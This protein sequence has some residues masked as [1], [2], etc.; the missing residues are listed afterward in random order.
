[1]PPTTPAGN[2]PPHGVPP[3]RLPVSTYR[4]QF[5]RGFT[6]ADATAVVPYLVRLGI[7]D[8]YASP[9]L[10]ACIGS[11]HGYDICD[12]A[13]LNPE[14]GGDADYERLIA[15]LTAH[16]MGQVADVVPNHMAASGENPWWRDVLENGRFS[17]YAEWFDID[18]EGTGRGARWSER[19]KAVMTGAGWSS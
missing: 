5:H 12:H 10:K 14:V 17:P 18:W 3:R 2:G 13:Q 16:G 6:F 7:T 4:L 11:T 9:Y 19:F 8:C 1:M 15:V